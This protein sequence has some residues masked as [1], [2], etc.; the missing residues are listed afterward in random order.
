MGEIAIITFPRNLIIAEK[1]QKFLGGEIIPGV[2]SL[3]AAAATLR[4]QLTLNGIT[5]TLIITRPAGETLGK[6]SIYELS[7]HNATMAIYLGTH[8]LRE[9]MDKVAYPKDAPAAVVYHASWNDEEVVLGTVGDI[10]DRAE[11]LGIDKS[12]MI[13]IGNVL[14]PE[15]YKRSHLYG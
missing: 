3:F 10:A 13:I 4:T 11:A 1:I 5:E 12:A 6:D 8:K 9:I 7:R 2:T 14:S 15:N